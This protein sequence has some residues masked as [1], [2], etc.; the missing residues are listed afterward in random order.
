MSERLLIADANVEDSI[1]TAC[2]VSSAYPRLAV[3]C[4]VRRVSTCDDNSAMGPQIDS[5][6]PGTFLTDAM[7]CGDNGCRPMTLHSSTTLSFNREM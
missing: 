5:P 3:A 2:S 7:C 6:F 4:V 1:E